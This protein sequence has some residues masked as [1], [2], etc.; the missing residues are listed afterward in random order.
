MVMLDKDPCV[1]QNV[2]FLNVGGTKYLVVFV[3]FGCSHTPTCEHM[4]SGFWDFVNFASIEI[5]VIEIYSVLQVTCLFTVN[6][7]RA[8]Y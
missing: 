3:L 7:Q 5:L 8:I 6:L 4:S 2:T 1:G